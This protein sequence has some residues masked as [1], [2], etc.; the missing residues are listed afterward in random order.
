M[1]H[2]LMFGDSTLF[3]SN[4]HFRYWH[5]SD[6]GLPV[7]DV[8]CWGRSGHRNGRSPLPILTQSGHSAR[9]S[10]DHLRRRGRAATRSPS[11]H[12]VKRSISRIVLNGR[13]NE[14]AVLLRLGLRLVILVD[15]LDRALSQERAWQDQHADEAARPVG[16][17]LGEHRAGPDPYQA[18]PGPYEVERPSVSMRMPPSIRQ[19]IPGPWWRCR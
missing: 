6:I 13:V 11:G 14:D 15:V 10:F 7:R 2:G 16:R 18:A 5:F 4:H 1:P 3:S 17:C 9:G 12:Y 8:R 19:R